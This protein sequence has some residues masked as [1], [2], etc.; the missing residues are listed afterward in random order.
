LEPRTARKQ[1]RGIPTKPFDRGAISVKKFL[2][3]G[4][5]LAGGLCFAGAAQAQITVTLGGYTEFF[6]AYYDDDRPG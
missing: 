2:L 5:A 4:S 1:H 3:A 6:G